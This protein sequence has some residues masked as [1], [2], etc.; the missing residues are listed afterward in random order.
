MAI[1]WMQAFLVSRLLLPL[2]SVCQRPPLR[3]CITSTNAAIPHRG[4]RVGPSLS[5]LLEP[6]ATTHRKIV[7]VWGPF[8][9]TPR[10]CVSK[11]V[12]AVGAFLVVQVVGFLA[13]PGG[14]RLFCWCRCSVAGSHV[15]GSGCVPLCS[16]GFRRSRRCGM[17][18]AFPSPRYGDSPV[19]MRFKNLGPIV[20]LTPRAVGVPH[21]DFSH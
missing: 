17:Q 5:F 6:Q 13:Q 19:S 2:L 3:P 11:A 9:S 7:P 15:L 10:I 16:C 8:A 18:E 4:T 20:A 1:Y 21:N 12:H 14:R